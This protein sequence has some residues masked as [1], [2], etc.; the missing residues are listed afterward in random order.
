MAQLF[1]RNGVWMTLER[2]QEFNKQEAAVVAT[3]EPVTEA[4]VDVIEVPV[5]KKP[6][7]SQCDSKGRFHKSGCPVR[8]NK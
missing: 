5:E 3:V 1:S 2:I 4:P 6:F 8:L 7:C